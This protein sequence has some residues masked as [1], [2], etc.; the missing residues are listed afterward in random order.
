MMRSRCSH[1]GESA[2]DVAVAHDTSEGTRQG[3]QG[4]Y[5][6]QGYARYEVVPKN[7]DMPRVTAAAIASGNEPEAQQDSIDPK[8]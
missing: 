4:G 3:Q 2:E 1:D 5:P 7:A 6:V 8:R